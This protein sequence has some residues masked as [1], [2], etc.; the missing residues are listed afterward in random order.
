MYVLSIIGFMSFSQ[1]TYLVS[2]VALLNVFSLFFSTPQK[3]ISDNVIHTLDDYNEWRVEYMVIRH[4]FAYI[5]WVSSFIILYFIGS[6][7]IELLYYLFFV[8]MVLV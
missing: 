3:V 6:I 4:L 2:F 7:E 1:F 5:G 8:I